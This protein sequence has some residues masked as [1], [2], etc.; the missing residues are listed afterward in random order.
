MNDKLNIR[1]RDIE[2][3]NYSLNQ[4]KLTKVNKEILNIIVKN[5]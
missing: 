3:D 5:N 1:L 2:N 4:I